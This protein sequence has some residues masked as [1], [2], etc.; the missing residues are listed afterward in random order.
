MAFCFADLVCQ[1]NYEWLCSMGWAHW[2]LEKNM[3]FNQHW[4]STGLSVLARRYRNTHRCI[5]CL[6]KLSE[7]QDGKVIKILMHLFECFF[8]KIRHLE[9]PLYL[10]TPCIV[11]YSGKTS[12]FW[13]CCMNVINFLY[14]ILTLLVSKSICFK[15]T[16]VIYSHKL[17]WQLK[18]CR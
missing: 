5:H 7:L 12:I 1:E 3:G 11:A 16:A 4:S 15:K 10:C 8:Y 17:H 9:S 13:L 18:A 6:L 14:L 2:E